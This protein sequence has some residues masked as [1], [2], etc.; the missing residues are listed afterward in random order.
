MKSW[1]AR[2]AN[3]DGG[4][5]KTGSPYNS[6]PSLQGQ[7]ERA[8]PQLSKLSH[9]ARGGREPG[10]QGGTATWKRLDANHLAWAGVWAAGREGQGPG[11]R[12]RWAGGWR[13]GA[14]RGH[15]E[16]PTF[17]PA[18]AQMPSLQAGLI[19][20]ADLIPS[21]PPSQAPSP[22]CHVDCRLSSILGWGGRAGHRHPEP[23]ALPN[24]KELGSGQPPPLW[25]SVSPPQSEA[26]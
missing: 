6:S 20:P 5:H 19:Q 17:Q 8:M 10:G 11:R 1:Q 14:G 9:V 13:V 18:A 25:A 7:S 22:A 23:Q 3:G 24:Q 16:A 12:P 26:Q 21:C 4:Q 2:T 15:P